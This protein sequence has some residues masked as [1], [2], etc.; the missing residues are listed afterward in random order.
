[1]PRITMETPHTLGSEE[2]TR[3]LKDKFGA[4]RAKYGTQVHNLREQWADH[5]FSFE[6]STM[7]MGVSGTVQVEDANVK[8]DA[9]LPFA[10]MLFKGVIEQRIR[11]ELGGLLA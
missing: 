11:Q 9:H 4:V 3:R 10:A 1:M 8:L 7:G 5:T 6:F 2:A